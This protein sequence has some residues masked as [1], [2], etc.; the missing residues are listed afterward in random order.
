MASKYS[1]YKLALEQ[2][3]SPARRAAVL[4]RAEADLSGVTSEEIEKLQKVADAIDEA[5]EA[6]Q[7]W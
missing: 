6:E 7:G 3:G 5:E 2:A 4:L 1:E